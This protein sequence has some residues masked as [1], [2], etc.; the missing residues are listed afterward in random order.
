MTLI[1]LFAAAATALPRK[2]PMNAVAAKLL[3]DRRAPYYYLQKAIRLLWLRRALGAAVAWC[4]PKRQLA[5]LSPQSLAS[6]ADLKRDGV[7]FLPWAQLPVQ[8]ISQLAEQLRGKPVYARADHATRRHPQ[9]IAEPAALQHNKLYHDPR[10]VAQMPELVAL[11]NHPQLLAMVASYIGAT[12]TIASMEAWW[13]IGHPNAAQQL[14]QDDMFHRDVDDLRFLKT[15]L[16]LTDVNLENGAHSF[17][18]QSHRSDQFVRRAPISVE[19]VHAAFGAQAV[20]PFAAPAGTLF[21]EDT[22]GIHRQ[23]PA[24]AGIRLVFSVIYSVS[25]LDPNSPPKPLLP[26]P[27]G[28]DAYINRV[29]FQAG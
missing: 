2:L 12:P 29:I 3:S 16:Y 21:M 1:I 24:V 22:W 19:Q 25:G 4:V 13:T 15:F 17:V 20:M 8:Q 26:L 5:P 10:D 18:K 28:L 11:A 14:A 6:L 9:Y 23:T 27:P 7:A